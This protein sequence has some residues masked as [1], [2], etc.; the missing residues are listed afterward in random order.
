MGVNGI[1][2]VA[3]YVILIAIYFM[4]PQILGQLDLAV[5]LLSGW[6]VAVESKKY[7]QGVNNLC[8]YTTV[9]GNKDVLFNTGRRPQK[10]I[11]NMQKCLW[12]VDR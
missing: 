7:T 8:R 1:I 11:F 6:G 12:Y 2:I 9:L 10:C 3:C 4:I 5:T